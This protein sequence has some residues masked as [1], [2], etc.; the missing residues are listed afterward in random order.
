M[1]LEHCHQRGEETD[2]TLKTN[3][4][5]Q[6]PKDLDIEIWPDKLHCAQEQLSAAKKTTENGI[7]VPKLLF[8]SQEIVATNWDSSGPV[9][10]SSKVPLGDVVD[11]NKSHIK[12]LNCFL[13]FFG[14]HW[15]ISVM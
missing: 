12:N 6:N 2:T 7:A 4:D 15:A 9:I 3:N 14:K 5:G 1:P 13:I 10:S 11:I 8:P